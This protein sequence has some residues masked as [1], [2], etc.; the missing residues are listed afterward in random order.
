MANSGFPVTDPA[1]PAKRKRAA[2]GP[3]KP[4]PL[5][6]FVKSDTEVTVVKTFRDPRDMAAYISTAH[7]NGEKLLIITPSEKEKA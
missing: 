6:T 1:A 3:R 7:T 4:S 2:S 5:Y